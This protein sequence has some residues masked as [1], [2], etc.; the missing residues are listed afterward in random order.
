MKHLQFFNPSKHTHAHADLK[1]KKKKTVGVDRSSYDTEWRCV[2][3]IWFFT[4]VCFQS[5]V[6]FLSF[7]LGC[8]SGLRAGDLFDGI[9]S[10]SRDS[11]TVTSFWKNCNLGCI[12]AGRVSCSVVRTASP[13]HL[14][15]FP[16][17]LAPSCVFCGPWHVVP[18]RAPASCVPAAGSSPGLPSY[19]PWTA[20]WGPSASEA[21]ASPVESSWAKTKQTCIKTSN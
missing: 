8:V 4:M 16:D 11:V 21:S 18:P 20:C 7:F 13:T 2:K 6:F 10:G 1:K 17:A 19:P 3:L 5:V 9:S 15:L 14:A 12:W